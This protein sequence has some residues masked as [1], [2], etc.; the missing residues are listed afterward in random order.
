MHV[1]FRFDREPCVEPRCLRC[2]LSYGR[3][4]Q[5]WRYTTHLERTLRN[6]DLFLAPSRFTLQAHRERG[7]TRPMRHLPHFLPGP[8]A[9]REG[10]RPHERPYALFV[11]RLERIKGLQTVIPLFR[12]YPRAELWI[13]GR[14]NDEPELRRLAGSSTNIR[15]LG[16]RGSDSL[17]QLYRDAVALLVPSLCY[18]VFPTVIIE[19]LQQ[20]TP[21]L[22]RALGG[23]REMI[24]ETQGGLLFRDAEELTRVRELLLDDRS[25]RERLGQRGREACARLYSKEAHLARYYALIEERLAHKGAGPRPG[26]TARGP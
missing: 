22:A 10:A 15:F 3:P 7:F 16:L 8:G 25:E 4:P 24:E 17:P 19:A 11:G 18:E 21:V 1:L 26:A 6:V 14:G 12:D 9:A 5:L 20:G 2:T 13:A 23:M